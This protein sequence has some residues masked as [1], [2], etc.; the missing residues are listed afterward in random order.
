M[1]HKPKEER[2]LVLIKPD[3]VKRGLAGEVVR[4]IEQRGLKIVALK[5]IWVTKD[6]I[7]K[8]YPKD[9]AWVHRLGEKSLGTYQKYGID[10]V[11]ALGTADADEIGKMVRGWIVDFMVSGPLVKMVVEGVHAID[12][13]RKLC[14]NT[15]PNLAEMGTIRGDYSVDSPALANSDK[16]AVHN[17]IHASET[18]EEAAHELAYWF[19]KDEIHDYKRAEEDIMF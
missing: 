18:S 16:R 17:I 3:G 19:S 2:T 9:P 13:V 4:R 10:P 12:M 8:H 6:Q 14:G 5:M 7:D 11:Q 1:T 15:L